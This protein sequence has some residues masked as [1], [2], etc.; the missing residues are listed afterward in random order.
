MALKP[1]SENDK[2]QSNISKDEDDENSLA[3]MIRGF[4]GNLRKRTLIKGSSTK[5]HHTELTTIRE[6][7]YSSLKVHQNL[8]LLLI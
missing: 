6:L 1:S 7:T 8:T 4:Q 2:D 3:M 5:M